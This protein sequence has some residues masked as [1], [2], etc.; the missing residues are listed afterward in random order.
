VS[1]STTE[2][3]H[4]AEASDIL[5]EYVAAVRR[6]FDMGGIVP[7]LQ[8]LFSELIRFETELWNAIDGRLRAD[9][10]LPLS[11]FEPMQVMARYRSCRVQ[12]I[13]VELG[14]TVGGTSK[15]VDRIEALGHCGRRANPDDRR[16]SIVELTPAGRRL[17]ARA[18]AAVQEE[19][20]VRLGSAL[21]TRSLDQFAAT[22][23]KL[24]SAGHELAAQ[25]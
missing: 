16:S 18:T 9:F 13:A 25:S 2:Q 22:L 6:S 1:V 19:L 8:R 11:R 21:S 20:E 15:L 10:D 12:D 23:A 24:R 5:Q 3:P 14:I 4:S 7:D 17:L